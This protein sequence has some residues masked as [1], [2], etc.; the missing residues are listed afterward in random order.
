MRRI[1]PKVA[2]LVAIAMLALTAPAQAQRAAA[3][4]AYFEFTDSTRE[5]AV[6][7]LTDPAKIQHARELVTGITNDRPHIL[8][9][10][11]KRPAPYNP[12]WSY[13][14]NPETVDFFDFAI[15]VCDASIPYV[16][17]HLDEAGGAFLPGLIWCPWSSRLVREIPVP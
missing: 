17:D 1:T 7:K 13:H 14:Y 15:E 3:P 16:E 5:R 8:G 4:E 12:R 6:L 10:I 11:V 9:R 2:A